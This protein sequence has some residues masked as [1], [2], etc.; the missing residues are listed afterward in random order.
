MNSPHDDNRFEELMA[1]VIGEVDPTLEER[2]E[3]DPAAYLD[4]IA[5]GER[6]S[7]YSNELL[8][9]AVASARAA[10]NSWE[11]IGN[12]LGVSR[13]AAQQRFPQT[14][15]PSAE[16]PHEWL[17]QPLTAFN[18]MQVL[19]RVGVYGWHSVGYGPYYHLLEKSDKQWQHARILSFADQGLLRRRGWQRIA[20]GWFPWAYYKRQLREPALP[21]P[22]YFDPL[23]PD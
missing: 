15:L 22:P 11:A 12:R 4:L 18:E 10:G 14:P 2:L 13:Q 9:S 16:E 6:M 21:E 17:L 8:R 19:G 20:G 3:N 5:W 23:M 7:R 1:A